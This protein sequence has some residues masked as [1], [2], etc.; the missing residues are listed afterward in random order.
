VRGSGHVDLQ[1]EQDR[2]DQ[3]TLRQLARMARRDNVAVRN[4]ASN[5][6]PLR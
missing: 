5:V 2:R 6:R 1:T 4:E 3:T